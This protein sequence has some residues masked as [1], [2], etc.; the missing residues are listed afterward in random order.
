MKEKLLDPFLHL[1]QGLVSDSG[2]IEYGNFPEF[3]ISLSISRPSS[4]NERTKS[5]STASH[6]KKWSK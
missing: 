1:Q 4:E 5:L 2:F 3:T 6:Q